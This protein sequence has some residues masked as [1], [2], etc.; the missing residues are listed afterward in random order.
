[1]SYGRLDV[2]IN[3]AGGHDDHDA[4]ASQGDNEAARQALETHL[5]GSWRLSSA[6][7]PLMRRSDYRRI[8]SVSSGCAATA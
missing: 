8:V 2:L 3:D 6:M 1:M 4:H 7:L 5:F